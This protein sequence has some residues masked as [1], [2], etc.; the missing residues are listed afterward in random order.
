LAAGAS[1]DV[2]VE[3]E[4]PLVDGEALVAVVYGDG[5]VAGTFEPGGADT[6]VSAPV[7]FVASVPVGTPAVRVTL[8]DGSGVFVASSVEPSTQ[9][10]TV[11]AEASNPTLQLRE[12]WRYELVLA[13]APLG[14][15]PIELVTR[16]ATAAE[17]VVLVGAGTD[18]GTLAAEAEI[19]ADTS[20]VGALRFTVSASLGAAL[21]GYRCAVDTDG[22]RG[23]ITV[24]PSQ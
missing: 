11:G 9:A 17:D 24:S 18:P 14:T 7:A 3:L 15:H 8:D 19:G 20:T 13:T 5:G 6:T 10:G 12:G 2:P 21:D 22:A 16:G 4:R 1:A 23:M